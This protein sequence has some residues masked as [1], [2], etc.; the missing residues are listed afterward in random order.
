MK[1]LIASLLFISLSASAFVGTVGRSTALKYDGTVEAASV[2]KHFINV[3]NAYGSS[4]S[5][6]AAVI[7]DLT[8]DDGASVTIS[9]GAGYSPLCIMDK[10]CAAN[11]LCKCQVY[12]IYDAALFDSTST[13]AVAGKRWVMSTNNAGYISARTTDLATEAQGGIFYDAASA[14]GTVQVFINLK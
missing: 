2:E 1:L 9:T 10:A 11:K 12:G 14:S 3:K 8:A 6:G 5:A 4:I 13:A 7:L